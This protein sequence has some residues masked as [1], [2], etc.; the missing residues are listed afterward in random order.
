[1][2]KYG[3]VSTRVKE[4]KVNEKN[5]CIKTAPFYVIPTVLRGKVEGSWAGI[6]GAPLSWSGALE[7]DFNK[8]TTP[9]AFSYVLKPQPLTFTLQPTV[10]I[11][12][13]A[14]TDASRRAPGAPG[15]PYV[16]K[17]RVVE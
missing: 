17:V 14:V 6:K 8:E 15:N 12:A 5:N 11:V 10:V 2:N 13:A 1:M 16:V 4:G 3:L 7:F 9:G